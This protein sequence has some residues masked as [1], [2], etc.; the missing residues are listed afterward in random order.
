MLFPG[1]TATILG[2]QVSRAF[3]DIA[4]GVV[5]RGIG[6]AFVIGGVFAVVSVLRSD[7][8]LEVIGYVF[9]ALGCALF[10]AGAVLGLGLLG[11][12]SGSVNIAVAVVLTD[13]VRRLVKEA[14]ARE[15]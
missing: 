15:R 7:R 9:T 12:M 11:V 3:T 14:K 1:L 4:G 6:S 2:D 13:L 8:S 5:I 10:G